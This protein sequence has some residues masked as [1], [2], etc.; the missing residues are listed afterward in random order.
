MKVSV[1]NVLCLFL[2]LFA[3]KPPVPSSALDS[4]ENNT[5]SD[6]ISV[7]IAR[8]LPPENLALLNA[9][10]KGNPIPFRTLEIAV[11][12]MN[13][14]VSPAVKYNTLRGSS[15]RLRSRNRGKAGYNNYWGYDSYRGAR[16][17][18][19][20]F[21]FK[22]DRQEQFKHND[23]WRVFGWVSSSWLND[24]KNGKFTG[25][26]EQVK[27]YLDT[28]VYEPKQIA[29]MNKFL[30]QAEFAARFIPGYAGAE[31][32]FYGDSTTDRVLGVVQIVGDIATLGIGTS[33]KVVSRAATVTTIT[34]ASVRV[35]VAANKFANGQATSADG[36]DAFLATVEAGI[37][38]VSIV[39]IK[40]TGAKAFVRNADEAAL[41]SKQLGR[42]SDDIL[43]NGIS[44]AEMEKLVGDIPALNKLDDLPSN[45]G[46]KEPNLS[47]NGGGNK[48]DEFAGLQSSGIGKMVN[49]LEEKTLHFVGSNG[50]KVLAAGDDKVAEMLEIRTKLKIDFISVSSEGKLILTEVKQILSPKHMTENIEHAIEQLR[51]VEE[52]LYKRGLS[53]KIGGFE[54]TLPKNTPTPSANYFFGDGSALRDAGQK[55]IKINDIPIIVHLL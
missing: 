44:K 9:L 39:K 52:V 22:I 24:P 2:P 41:L 11:G 51:A 34:A 54:I 33:V 10:T 28:K 35:G 31:N 48:I 29:A 23:S 14:F 18:D 37:G 16:I 53:R 50:R 32:A 43:Q 25:T 3:C 15:G 40:L 27:Q 46:N 20:V 45:R 21:I 49:E 12:R 30:D 38:A 5:A 47:P 7:A 19:R 4:N 36:I 1:F 17:G 26:E 13:S 6:E 55:A 8:P 42:S